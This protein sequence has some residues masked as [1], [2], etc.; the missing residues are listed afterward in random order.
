[1]AMVTKM[2]SETQVLLEELNVEEPNVSITLNKIYSE[3]YAD[4]KELA[5]EVIHLNHDACVIAKTKRLNSEEKVT[6]FTHLKKAQQN[7]EKQINKKDP[8]SASA[9]EKLFTDWALQVVLMRFIQEYE[10]INGLLVLTELVKAVGYET[11]EV[12][13]AHV[14]D[15]FGQ[16][17]VKIALDVTLKVGMR[18]EKLQSVMLAD[19]FINMDMSG[20]K[21]DGTMEFLNCPIY[22]GHTFIQEK[23]GIEPQISTLFCKHFCFAHARAMLKQSCHFP[24]RCGSLN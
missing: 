14:K 22:G 19:H 21:L 7:V 1:M 2:E 18:R 8:K 4:A 15:D 5:K 3:F 16:K 9:L 12:A 24:S 10:T 6:L 13:M 11:V 17:T 23:Y 20:E